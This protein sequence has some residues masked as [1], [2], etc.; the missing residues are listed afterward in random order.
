MSLLTSYNITAQL[1]E[2]RNEKI[3]RYLSNPQASQGLPRPDRK[4]SGYAG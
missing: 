4:I 3:S 2:I 1:K